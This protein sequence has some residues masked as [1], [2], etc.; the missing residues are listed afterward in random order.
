MERDD[1]IYLKLL[2]MQSVIAVVFLENSSRKL[3]LITSVPLRAALL[4]REIFQFRRGESL[5][6]ELSSIDC[7]KS[8]S[9]SSS[10]S[11]H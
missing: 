3:F 10:Y 6:V 2:S 7:D 11:D 5:L 4:V 9:L 8:L 1:E